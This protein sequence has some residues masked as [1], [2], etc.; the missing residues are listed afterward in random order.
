MFS[1][2]LTTAWDL[3]ALGFPP[4]PL[5]LLIPY[6]LHPTRRAREAGTLNPKPPGTAPQSYYDYD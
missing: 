2:E 1:L 6:S 5:P 3:N 4:P